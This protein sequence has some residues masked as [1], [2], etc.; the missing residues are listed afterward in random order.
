M[1]KQKP[2]GVYWFSCRQFTGEIIVK[3]GIIIKGCPII[4]TF[5]GQSFWNLANWAKGDIRWKK[6]DEQSERS[7]DEKE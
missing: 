7:D 2:S 1:T 5:I 6:I 3:N 4:K